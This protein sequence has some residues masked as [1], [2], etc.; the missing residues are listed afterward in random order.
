[1]P[2][3][4]GPRQKCYVPLNLFKYGWLI[5]KTKLSA[6]AKDFGI[7]RV[8]STSSGITYGANSPKPPTATKVDSTGN[9][10][11]FFNPSKAK[12]LS[13][14]GYLLKASPKPKRI[15]LMGKTLTVYV[16]TNAGYNYAW[17]L[18]TDDFDI[19]LTAGVKQA[20]INTPNLVWGSFPKPP[21]AYKKTEAGGFSTF[22]PPT[23]EGVKAAIA[24][25]FTVESINPA[26]G[27]TI[28][29]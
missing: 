24:A 25:G 13:D 20:A 5:N 28:I 7:T 10:S 8:I 15:K 6:I 27:T 4:R 9:I 19:A 2:R 26:W 16:E 22:C 29:I 14:A 12:T 3:N 21:R 17:N 11:S 23:P 18:A 1:M